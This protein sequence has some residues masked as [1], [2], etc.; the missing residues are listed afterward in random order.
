MNESKETTAQSGSKPAEQ[1][2]TPPPASAPAPQ[3]S[4]AGRRTLIFFLSLAAAFLLGLVPMWITAGTNA[5]ERDAARR[6]LRLNQVQLALASAAIDARRGEYEPARLSAVNFYTTL[7]AEL[8]RGEDS[9]FP[10]AQHEALQA[11]FRQRD[12]LITLLARSDPA[13]AELLSN[14]HVAY[15]KAAQR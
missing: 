9:A 12:D 6:E 4:S 7:T 10:P 15:R 1:T 8:G 5:R 13:S 11:L 14:L 3:H 2:Y